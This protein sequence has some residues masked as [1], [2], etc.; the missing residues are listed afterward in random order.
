[1]R[2][3]QDEHVL[4]RPG[5]LEMSSQP[6]TSSGNP[7]RQPLTSQSLPLSWATLHLILTQSPGVAYRFYYISISFNLLES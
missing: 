3:C 4:L 7:E 5:I 6:L 2:I 1:M